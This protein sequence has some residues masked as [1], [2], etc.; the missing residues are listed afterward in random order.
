ME[1][2]FVR[3][4]SH[5]ISSAF[6][7]MIHFGEEIRKYRST[8]NENNKNLVVFW[9]FKSVTITSILESRSIEED[10]KVKND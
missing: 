5:H 9:C 10:K 6:W 3:H 4:I 2:F 1:Q 8:P 7:E